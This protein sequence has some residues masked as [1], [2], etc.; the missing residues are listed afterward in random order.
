M[1]HVLRLNPG[2]SW[3][4]RFGKTLGY[5]LYVIFHPFDGFWDLAREKRGSLAAAHVITFLLILIEIMRLTL[6]NFQFVS[7]YKAGLNVVTVILRILLPM[8][9]WTTANWSL[10]TLMDGKGKA[11]EIYMA[12]A[13]A[14]TPHV[15]INAALIIYSQF[16]TFQEGALYYFFAVFSIV[17]S[18]L[19]VLVAMMMIHEYSAAKA[20]FSSLLTIVAMGVM[21]FVFLIFF[22]LISD[23]IAFF[24]SLF[25]EIFYRVV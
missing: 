23:A 5:A 11:A 16:I 19:L 10:T 8:F 3:F 1:N 12:T 7:V 2:S 24:V 20:I 25:K 18:I 4:S 17:W 14:F 6:T 15:I 22:T 9:L 13:Y 21:M